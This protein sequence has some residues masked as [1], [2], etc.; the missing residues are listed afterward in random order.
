MVYATYAKGYK[1]GGLNLNA[2]GAPPVI[3]PEKVDN[4]EAGIKTTLFDR[5][6]TLNLAAFHTRIRNYQSQQVDVGGALTAYIANVGTVRTQGIEIDATVRPVR[7]LSLFASG[8]Y[9]DAIYKNF[10]NAPCPVEYLG[11][12]TSCDLSGRNLPGVSKYS[13][14]LGGDYAFDVSAAAQ[15][16]LNANY[17]YRSRFNGTYNLAEDAVIKGYGVTNLRIGLRHPDGRWDVSLYARNLFD[18]KYFNTLGP[19]AFNTGQYSGGPGEPR[20]YGITL[21]TSL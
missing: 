4:Y 3:D 7:N 1:S 5:A 2:T 20:T 12:Q 8:S 6:M 21:R 10:R 17:S 9:I 19:A 14:S 15:V 11:L 16:Y 13:L 18:T